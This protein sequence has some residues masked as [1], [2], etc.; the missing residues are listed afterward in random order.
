MRGGPFVPKSQNT[1]AEVIISIQTASNWKQLF[2]IT[3]GG[4]RIAIY[5]IGFFLNSKIGR[6]K[7]GPHSQRVN[8]TSFFR[9][10]S[11]YFSHFNFTNSVS[12]PSLIFLTE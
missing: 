1:L 3:T 9:I 8:A 2:Q 11:Y 10:S 5:S 4:V 12:M 6:F 7:F